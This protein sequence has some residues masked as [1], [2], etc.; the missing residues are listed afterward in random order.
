MNI[1]E[2]QAKELLRGVGIATPKGVVARTPEEAERAAASLAPGLVVVKAQIHAGGRGK[3]GG[4]KLVRSPA[5]TGEAARALLGKALVTPQTGPEGRVVQTVLVEEGQD[6]ATEYYAALTLDRRTGLP[7]FIVSPDGGMDIEEVAERSPERIFRAPIDPRYGLQAF[8]GRK[9]AAGLGL[10]GKALH[11]GAALFAAMWELYKGKDASLVEINPLVRLKDGRLMALDAKCILDDNALCRH[12]DCAVLA[13][14]NESNPLELEAEAYGLNYIRLRGQIGAVVNGA[15]LAMATMDLIQQAGGSPA[16]F[17]DVGGGAAADKIAAGVRIILSDEQVT[18]I[19]VNIFGGILR[20]D[21]LA[22]GLIRAAG[23][24][25]AA[26][27]R[28]PPLIVRMLG[29]NAEKGLD[30][31]KDSGLAYTAADDL[32]QAARALADAARA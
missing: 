5:E 32:E 14:P 23:E 26:G 19:F 12:P 30:M 16:N 20:C 6:I 4:V 2:Y 29:T 3:G 25:A 9:L 31:L 27:R 10:N 15:G 18:S 22:E 8:E 1:H 21:I 28:M 17:L 7:S 13:D 24:A 11:A